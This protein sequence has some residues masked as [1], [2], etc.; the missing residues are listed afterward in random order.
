[1]QQRKSDYK[2]YVCNKTDK[3][4]RQNNFHLYLKA[5]IHLLDVF[6]SQVYCFSIYWN[7]I[8]TSISSS[9]HSSSLD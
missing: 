9:S 5:Q 4:T 2:D 1:M 8:D 7:N 3:I 6:F